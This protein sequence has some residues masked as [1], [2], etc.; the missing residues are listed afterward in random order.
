M[1]ILVKGYTME[2][3]LPSFEDV[4]VTNELVT[5]HELRKLLEADGVRITSMRNIDNGEYYFT[6]AEVEAMGHSVATSNDNSIYVYIS[7]GFTLSYSHILK[8]LY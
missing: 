4:Y 1:R 7:D 5:I 8:Q 2:K 6:A 3:G